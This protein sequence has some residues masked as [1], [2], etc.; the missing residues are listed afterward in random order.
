MSCIVPRT[1]TE[2]RSD[3]V[4]RSRERRPLADFRSTSAYVLLGNPGSGKTTA[5]R[6]EYST[7]GQAAAVLISARDFRTFEPADHPEWRDKTIFIDGL[8]EV[9]AGSADDRTSMDAIRRHLE[10]L[11]KPPFR[12]SCRQ[13]DWLGVNDRRRL[14]SVAPDSTVAVLRLDPLTEPDVIQILTARG[15]IHDVEEFIAAA[16]ARGVDALL[17][18]PQTLTMLADV[19]APAGDWPESRLELFE[20]ACQQMPAER[21]EEHQAAQARSPGE[22][23]SS[24]AQLLDGAGRLCAVQLIADVAGYSRWTPEADKRYPAVDACESEGIGAGLLR[25]V[26]ATKLFGSSGSPVDSIGHQPEAGRFEPIHRHIAEFLAARYLARLVDGPEPAGRKAG[27]GL[28]V[29]RVLSLIAGE[30]G[31]VV[32]TLRG[33]SAWLAAQCES[34]R[35][36]LIA[37]DPVGVSLYGDI[38][39]FTPEQKR[40]LLR[41]LSGEASRLDARE[42]TASALGSIATADLQPTLRETLSD[43]R[44]SDDQHALVELLLRALPH[45]SALPG[46]S[47]TLMGIVR[48]AT[49]RP[50]INAWALDAFIHSR[51]ANPG[52]ETLDQLKTLIEDIREGRVSDPENELAGVLLKQLYPRRLAPSDVWIYLS[53]S[54]RTHTMIGGDYRRFWQECLIEQSSDEDVAELL[55]ILVQRLPTLWSALS[56]HHVEQMPLALLARGLKTCGD[57]LDTQRLYDWLGVGLA[58]GMDW[59]ES[60]DPIRSWLREH[61]A[62]WKAILFEGLKRTTASA[63]EAASVQEFDA[64]RRLYRSAQPADFC[65]WCLDQ[66]V[67]ASD[68]RIARYFVLKAGQGLSIELLEERARGHEELRVLVSEMKARHRALEAHEAAWRR[69]HAHSE[70]AQEHRRRKWTDTV[71]AHE[72]ELRENRCRPKMLHQ[73]AQGYFGH[74]YE[75][76]GNEPR[77]RLGSLFRND[78]RLI[79][80]ALVGL[81]GTLYRDDVPD[82]EEIFRLRG[83]NRMHVLELS[84]L[85]G[86]AELDRTAPDELDRLDE[87]QVRSALA[88]RYRGPSNK[89]PAWYRRIL[90]RHPNTVADVLMQSVTSALRM[91]ESPPSGLYELAYGKNHA[92]VARRASLPLLRAFPVRCTGQQLDALDHLLWSAC[93]HAER[94]AF[95]DLIEHR[96]SAKSMNVGQRVRWLAAGLLTAP[97]SYRGRLKHYVEEGSREGRTRHLAAFLAAGLRSSTSALVLDGDRHIPPHGIP[98]RGPGET[99]VAGRLGADALAMVAQ[100]VA[101]SFGPWELTGCSGVRLEMQASDCVN[102]FIQGLASLPGM[103]AGKALETLAADPELSKW[104]ATLNQA[105]A[106][107][108]VIW[109]DAAFRHPDV[110]QVCQTLKNGPPANAGDLAALVSDRLNEI[111]QRT[112]TA[113]TDDWRQYWNVN[114]YGQPDRSRPENSC[115]DTLLSVLRERLPAPVDAQPEGHY[116]DGKRADIRVGCSGHHP[117]AFEVPVEI[118]KNLHRDLWRALR[119]Q[120]IAQ[121]TRDPATDGYGIYLVF[122]FGDSEGQTPLPPE[123]QRPANADELKERLEATLTVEEARKISVCVIDVSPPD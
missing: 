30:D 21:N 105:R 114:S 86:L 122:W 27:S 49:W 18:N 111:S 38:R 8:D 63:P 42:W 106:R 46:L 85:A 31:V 80:A 53:A 67:A 14:E 110:E 64:E 75:A 34:A 96:L 52:P 23:A 84:F 57:R 24:P 92:A 88:F 94:G 26:L 2:L 69:K 20:Y 58:P 98:G 118:K 50:Y 22:P 83:Q 74:L 115:R 15:G 89:E 5:F 113:N 121:Y 77:E 9:R 25:Q 71:R 104:C 13:A 112:R 3:E 7:L 47:D 120:L 54:V 39:S 99:L 100:I 35:D 107:Q 55:D 10:K 40:R 4:G 45:G 108:R 91:G 29:G 93:R 101:R 60:T 17:D 95:Q 6:Q 12:L 16:R 73:I 56:S 36:E 102:S 82:V 78:E 61:P 32:T 109:R 76:R 87:R 51:G 123:G 103:D 97:D 70:E 41:T 62:A 90:A 117:T 68:Q 1:C 65:S 43:G 79:E 11:G 119:D 116:A 28:P 33:L 72:I 44:R 66:A 37:R 81:R 59:D 48:D 19:V